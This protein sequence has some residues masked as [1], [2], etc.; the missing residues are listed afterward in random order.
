LNNWDAQKM[1]LTRLVKV[2]SD[3]H[4]GDDPEWLARYTAQLI[5]KYKDNLD[6]AITTFQNALPE[7][8]RIAYLDAIG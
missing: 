3:H 7:Y 4:G 2:L 5:N 8:Q 1:C 6:V